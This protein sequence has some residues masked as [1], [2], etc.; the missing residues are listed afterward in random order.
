MEQICIDDYSS[1]CTM[2]V[3][4]V[5]KELIFCRNDYDITFIYLDR[6]LVCVFVPEK[7]NEDIVKDIK[8][9]YE[10][11]TQVISM[12]YLH[13]ISFSYGLIIGMAMEEV[14]NVD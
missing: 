3:N 13:E 14:K 9:I 5:D 6:C 10:E 11:K 8:R 12:G 7:T 2:M 4:G 1:K